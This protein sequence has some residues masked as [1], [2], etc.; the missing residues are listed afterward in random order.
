[1]VNPGISEKNCE[2]IHSPPCPTTSNRIAPSRTA[3]RVPKFHESNRIFHRLYLKIS[4]GNNE[5]CDELIKVYED[6]NKLNFALVPDSN[7]YGK[8]HDIELILKSYIK[9]NYPVE[10]DSSNYIKINNE[11]LIFFILRHNITH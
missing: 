8:N 5:L 10:L 7:N 6:S 1:M 11:K 2:N 9:A 4:I 3:P